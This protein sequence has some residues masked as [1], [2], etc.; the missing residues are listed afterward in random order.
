MHAHSGT[1]LGKRLGRIGFVVGFI[2]PVL[3]YASPPSFFAFESHLLCPWCPIVDIFF[4]NS[5]TYLEVGLTT[6]LFSGLLLAFAG[7]G[8]GYA[9][10]GIARAS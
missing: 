1:K 7:F 8:I 6:G 3:F 10:S 4:A 2:G 9:I 5:L